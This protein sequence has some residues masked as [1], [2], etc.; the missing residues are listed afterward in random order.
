MINYL[1]S[2]CVAFNFKFPDHVFNFDFLKF[3]H[4]KLFSVLIRWQQKNYREEIKF[5]SKNEYYNL[6]QCPGDK[7]LHQK[8]TI[9][10]IS[11][12][13]RVRLINHRLV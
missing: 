1:I 7:F 3:E 4:V 13:H 9:E 8:I 5:E 11:L 2:F 6:T 10:D 12:K